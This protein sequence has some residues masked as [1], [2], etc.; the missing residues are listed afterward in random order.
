MISF[1]SRAPSDTAPSAESCA[2]R[3]WMNGVANGMKRV[4]TANVFRRKLSKGFG[5]DSVD[6]RWFGRERPP[7]ELKRSY[8]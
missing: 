6:K 5:A 1:L 8:L 2:R 3:F 4:G 7:E